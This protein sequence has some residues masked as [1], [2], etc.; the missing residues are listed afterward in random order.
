MYIKLILWKS[1]YLAFEDTHTVLCCIHCS[2]VL[3][4]WPYCFLVPFYWVAVLLSL[5]RPE[6]ATQVRP[7]N[8]PSSP[9]KLNLTKCLCFCKLAKQQSN[10]INVALPTNTSG[11]IINKKQKPISNFQICSPNISCNGSSAHYS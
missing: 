2:F 9:F 4:P 3:H 5:P 7:Q 1:P 8:K 10:V 6:R 11:E